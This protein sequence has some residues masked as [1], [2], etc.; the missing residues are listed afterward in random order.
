M[1]REG[2]MNLQLNIP[3]TLIS[4][5][6]PASR[7]TSRSRA[8]AWGAGAPMLARTMLPVTARGG[9]QGPCLLWD[10]HAGADNRVGALKSPPCDSMCHAM[11]RFG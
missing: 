10:M 1:P 8:G 9:L 3:L 7:H 2:M 6:T 11:V 5:S 4:D